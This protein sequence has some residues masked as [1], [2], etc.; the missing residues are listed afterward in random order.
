MELD[1]IVF[2]E[3]KSNQLKETASD[4]IARPLLQETYI[5]SHQASQVGV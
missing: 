1:G 5:Q 4:L 3:K 2:D